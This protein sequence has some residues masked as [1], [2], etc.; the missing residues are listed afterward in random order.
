MRI[1]VDNIAASKT[2]ALSILRDFYDF[3]REN[4][5]ENEWIFV[6]GDRLLDETD[7]IRV[8]VR[9]DVKASRK[10]RLMFDLRTGAGY[11]SDL[12]PDVL[13]SMQNTLPRGYKGR[14][15]LYV[16][17]P[18]PFQ[19]MKRFSFFKPQEREYA[20]YQYL[21]GKMIGASVKR[22]DKVIVQTQWMHDAVIKK[23]G[24]GADRVIK[25]LPDIDIPDLTGQTGPEEPSRW[26]PQQDGFFF[27]AGEILYKNHGCIL[28]AVGILNDRGIKDFTVSFT[29][30]KGDIPALDKYPE[31]E[32]VKYLGRIERKE[33]FGRY[34]S[35]ILLFP[36]YIETFGYPPAE[37]RAVGGRVIAS[38]CPFC[39][40]VLD[41]YERAAY[42]D[43]FDPAALAD[44]MERAIK[45]ELFTDA[46]NETVVCDTVNKRS[47]GEVIR[48]IMEVS[49]VRV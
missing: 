16:H 15:V 6:L 2:G 14:Q 11:F 30:N 47:W 21:I 22:A 25:I 37:A 5:K 12:K 41:G 43:P 8:I 33:V 45:G 7:N 18:L 3:I 42:F 10:N 39:H 1:V 20:V 46:D 4:D 35:Q 38:E 9:D 29:L 34:K 24:V 48:A 28:E 49:P 13:F 27:P 23:T 44:L 40:E 19:D 17:Q 26:H 31:Y 36:S 32:Q